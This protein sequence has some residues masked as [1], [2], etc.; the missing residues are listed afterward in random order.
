MTPM[1]QKN[2]YTSVHHEKSGKG[3]LTSATMD[4]MKAMSQARMEMDM[5]AS[6]NGSPM[7]LPKLSR[8]RGLGKCPSILCRDGEWTEPNDGMENV[9]TGVPFPCAAETRCEVAVVPSFAAPCQLRAAAARELARLRRG[10][11]TR[12]EAT[13]TVN[14]TGR[15]AAAVDARAR[16]DFEC[17]GLLCEA[18]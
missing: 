14:E 16:R 1:M 12:G 8:R 15:V 4:A 13:A 7:M 3:S 17:R 9:Q 6:A 10:V 2:M 5:V 11:E 18:K